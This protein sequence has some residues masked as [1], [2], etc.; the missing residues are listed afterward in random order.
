MAL[1]CTV[2]DLREIEIVKNRAVIYARYSSEKQKEASIEQQV[3]AC[4]EYITRKGYSLI[5]V[6]SDSAKS[7]S[8]NVEKR[9]DFLKLIEDAESGEFDVVVSYALDRISREEHGGFYGYE[10]ALNKNGVRF[11]YATQV[12]DDG[13]GGEISKA[14]H[15][16]MA[17]EYVAQLRKNVV[18]GMR[19]NVENGRFNGGSSIPIGIKIVGEGKKNKRYAVD[20][21]VC[22]YIKQAFEMYVSGQ[23]TGDIMEFLN[24]NGV[25]TSR[26]KKVSRDTVNRMLANP[27][28]IG[29]RVSKFNNKVEH[30]VYTVD[31]VCEPIISEE[32]WE[33]TQI[34]RQKRLNRGMTEAKR[35]KYILRGKLFCGLCGTEMVADCG[36]SSTGEKYY[37]YT[38]VHRKQAKG[39]ERCRKQPV[40]KELLE[41]CVIEIITNRL[42][43]Q[44]MIDE[45]ACAARE[46]AK[47][48]E[49]D[50]QIVRLRTEIKSH[51]EKKKRAMQCYLDTADTE[52]YDM[53]KDEARLLKECEAE[54][55]TRIRQ[56]H[57]P[58]NADE[59]LAEIRQLRS[60]WDEMLKTDAGRERIVQT[61][62]E[63]I[64]I[65]DPAPDDPGKCR[66][67]LLIRTDTDAEAS[68]HVQAEVECAVRVSEKMGHHSSRLKR[69]GCFILITAVRKKTARIEQG[70]S[71]ARETVRW[72]VSAPACV[73]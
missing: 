51:A 36:R 40:P 35:K 28:Y 49:E 2:E 57:A 46:A 16:T 41:N 43:D 30:K 62:V 22:P 60:A 9:S 14:V 48:R 71:A 4:M 67:D 5:R 66:L 53:S 68:E 73:P 70:A 55:A 26:G 52:W 34:S 58:K 19:D 23:T 65:F 47:K 29:R 8:H 50:P 69:V 45:Y 3:N 42:W 38:C 39:G 59:F 27:I 1:K 6:Y 54:L 72:T 64:D 7:A 10:N 13:Y 11:E 25:R 21:A 61:Y 15:V 17:S 32:L 37:Y 33:R 18:R 24:D 12:F 44:A 31:G 56:D 20:E 63:R